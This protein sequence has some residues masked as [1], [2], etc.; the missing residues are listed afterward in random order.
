MCRVVDPEK[1]FRIRILLLVGFG[2]GSVSGSGSCY[3]SYMNSSS[4]LDKIFNL[5][6]IR[7]LIL[8]RYKLFR[9]MFFCKKDFT[10]LN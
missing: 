8:T 3:E 1:I 2:S 10:C 6:C 4:I 9:G 7:L 5:V